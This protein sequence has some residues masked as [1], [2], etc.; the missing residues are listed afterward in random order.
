MAILQ[1]GKIF[2]LGN[3]QETHSQLPKGVYLLE[4]DNSGFY[5]KEKDNFIL[6]K[7]IYGDHSIVN[8]WIKS[9]EHN[10]EKNMGI[11]LSGLKGTGK[12]ITA[13]KFCIDIDLP[14]IMINAAYG[15]PGFVDF[16]TDSQLGKCIVFIDEFEKVYDERDKQRDLLSLMD[17]QYPTKL[18]FMLTC[19]EDVRNPY[20]VNRLNRIKYKKTY[21]NLDHSVMEAVID[22]LLEHKEHKDSIFEFFEVINLCTFDL[23]VN[24][25]KEINLFN[26]PATVCGEHLNLQAEVQ[27]VDIHEIYEGKQYPCNTVRFVPG[28]YLEINRKTV[29]YLPEEEQIKFISCNCLGTEVNEYTLEKVKGGRLLTV[30]SVLEEDEDD[31]ESKYDEVLE[32]Y[33]TIHKPKK[34]SK[35]VEYKFLL[36]PQTSTSIFT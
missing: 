19:N 28:T 22:D 31:Y 4:A 34:E 8:R 7:K 13:Q 33:V 11:L 5:L 24:I 18:I 1:N 9:F 2:R 29:D 6:P 17:G 23:L 30:K 16:M 12:T 27:Y 26:E 35:V 15:G 32:D 20:L 25:I 36:T 10:S 21:Y 14:V 3:A